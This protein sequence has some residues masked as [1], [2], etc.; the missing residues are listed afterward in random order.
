ML[1]EFIDPSNK[2]VTKFTQFISGAMKYTNRFHTAF[3]DDI[4]I[5]VMNVTRN[6]MKTFHQQ[7]FVNKINLPTFI[8]IGNGSAVSSIDHVWHNLNVPRSSYVVFPALSDHYAVCVIFKVEHD[9]PPKTIRFPYFSDVNT[10]HFAENIEAEFHLCL[11][12]VM[13]PNEYAEQLVNFLKKKHYQQ[14]FPLKT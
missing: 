11:P 2:P 8:S 4:N 6:Y 5:Y 3:T 9:S 13:N 7:S 14:I 12:P 1:Q 10:E